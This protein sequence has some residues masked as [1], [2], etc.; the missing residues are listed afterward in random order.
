M[1]LPLNA[2]EPIL[3]PDY[4][5]LT[6]RSLQPEPEIVNNLTV[7]MYLRAILCIYI[8]L[9]YSVRDHENNS[10]RGDTHDHFKEHKNRFEEV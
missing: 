7:F 4:F 1:N 3:L 8:Y 9:I 10:I 5:S 2:F 6:G